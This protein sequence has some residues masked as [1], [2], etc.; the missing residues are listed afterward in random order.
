MTTLEKKLR[1]RLR[2]LNISKHEPLLV[3]VSGGAD[4]TALLDAL[5]RWKQ[6]EHLFAAH[7]NHQLRGA[8]SDADETFVRDL[9][10]Q[11]RVSVFIAREDVAACAAQEKKNLEAT[12]RRLRYDF[13]QRTAEQCQA[14][15][16]VTAHTR[17][18]QVETILLRLL[19][20]TSAAGLQGIHAQIEL[21][22]ALRLVRPLLE[23]PRAEVLEHCARYQLQF[24]HDSSNESVDFTRNRVRHELLPLLKTF[25]PNV[26]ATLLR[27]A[28][29]L[30]EDDEYLQAEAARW[31]DE[32]VEEQRLNFQ[33]LRGLSV[34]LRR[35]VLRLWLEKTRGD[36]RRISTAHLMALDDLM[37][38]GEG[39]SYIE[40]PGGWCVARRRQQLKLQPVAG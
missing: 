26:S 9:T 14:R 40:L 15:V 23:I 7:L 1:A 36:L 27:T 25:N 34:A 21:E 29:Q 16:I 30:S 12:A 35:R 10:R 11:L 13:L 5:A 28:A 38:K 3:A 4:S 2:Q 8:E 32:L 37:M 24:Q 18:D 6:S 20:G 31:A 17:D 19:R 22:P 33:P 39:G